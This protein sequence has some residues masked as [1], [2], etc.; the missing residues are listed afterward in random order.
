M[1]S[2]MC[3]YTIIIILMTLPRSIIVQL[4]ICHIVMFTHGMVMTSLYHSH[5]KTGL[6][7]VH[8]KYTEITYG[9]VPSPQL[10][11]VCVCVGAGQDEMLDYA[12][13][14]YGLFSNT[15]K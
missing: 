13:Y 10:L 2:K 14:N 15:I 5:W 7:P 8:T 4:Q 9:L 11:I 3:M 1:F 6:D 12:M